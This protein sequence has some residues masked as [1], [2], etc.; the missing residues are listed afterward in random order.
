MY[1]TYLRKC[2]PH[3]RS[4]HASFQGFIIFDNLPADWTV[5][6]AKPIS[7]WTHRPVFFKTIERR[8]REYPVVINKKSTPPGVDQ[9]FV[10]PQQAEKYSLTDDGS[11]LSSPHIWPLPARNPSVPDN[12]LQK[13]IGQSPS[14]LPSGSVFP[15]TG[16]ILSR[17]PAITCRAVGHSLT[18]IRFFCVQ[19]SFSRI[20][21]QLFYSCRLRLSSSHRA[22]P[23]FLCFSHNKRTM[24][25][26]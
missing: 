13:Q 19:F 20:A 3:S 22:S 23:S 25:F 15:I 24:L 8:H 10:Y 9:C 12:R 14:A 26:T 4:Y 2:F 5:S 21:F 16:S 17:L 18:R 1:F 6:F 11:L 7:S